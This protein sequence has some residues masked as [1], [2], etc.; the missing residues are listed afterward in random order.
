MQAQFKISVFLWAF[1]ATTTLILKHECMLKDVLN[2]YL[3][4]QFHN[5]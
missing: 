4:Y 1:E 5:F 2:I 3:I